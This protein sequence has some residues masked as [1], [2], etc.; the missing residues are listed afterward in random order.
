MDSLDYMKKRNGSTG[1]EE[2]IMTF[3]KFNEIVEADKFEEL[4]KRYS[5]KAVLGAGY[6]TA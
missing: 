2:R 6:L 1:L 3:D 4:E 5:A